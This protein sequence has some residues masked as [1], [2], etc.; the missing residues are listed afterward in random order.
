ME[1]DSFKCRED[2]LLLQFCPKEI[3]SRSAEVFA[4]LATRGDYLINGRLRAIPDNVYGLSET[5]EGLDNDWL[6]CRLDT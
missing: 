6:R 1:C 3:V 4:R 2:E 5:C